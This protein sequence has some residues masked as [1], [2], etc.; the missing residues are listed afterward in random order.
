MKYN[1]DDNKQNNVVV[2]PFAGAWIEIFLNKERMV[3]FMVAPFAGAW[4]EIE[5]EELLFSCCAVAPFAGAWIEIYRCTYSYQNCSSRSL[6][7]SVD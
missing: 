6:R 3:D 7:G 5:F 4:I 2:A 1:I